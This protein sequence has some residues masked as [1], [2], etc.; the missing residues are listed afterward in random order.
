MPSRPATAA[1]GPAAS[2]VSIDTSTPSSRI[3]AR[4]AAA[5]GRRVSPT[6]TT[7]STRPPAATTAPV[8]PSASTRAR[9][10]WTAAGRSMPD[11]ANSWRRP[12]IT[13]RP[14]TRARTPR[15]A[16][17]AKST[18]RGTSS[19]RS[20]AACTRAA[21][22]GC[23][24]DRSTAAARRS[25]PAESPSTAITSWTRMRPVV[26]VPVLSNTTVSMRPQRSSTS[27]LRIRMP[28]A[29][30]RPVPTISATGVASPSAQG[31]AMISTAVAART[32]CA[33]SPRSTS[34]APAVSRLR[35]MI[36]GTNTPATRSASRCTGAL[37][38][39]ASST[40]RAM[41]ARAVSA[42]TAVSWTSSAPSRA[43]VPPVTASPARLSTGTG[44]PVSIDSSTALAPS[45][46]RPS[47][48]MRS[49]GRT[50]TTS[51]ARRLP[52]GTRRSSTSAPPPTTSRA[53]PGVRVRMPPIAPAA[54]RRARDSIQRPS[55]R[56]EMISAAMS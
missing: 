28:F 46:T 7:P 12:T 45:S 34:Q 5:S 6:A 1:A 20:R 50:R 16:Q 13:S 10:T 4:A 42:P 48:G 23:S 17:A 21:P 27:P 25:R 37:C 35:P 22:T 51:P 54:R 29:A 55:R 30:A 38:A 15:P 19:R 39:C 53:S 49:P 43:R 32:A 11:C 33:G 41:R 26:R 3:S 8:Q 40:S 44:S 31:Q 2:P 52:T 18:A 24:E 36:T 14:S 9:A 56:K 47:A